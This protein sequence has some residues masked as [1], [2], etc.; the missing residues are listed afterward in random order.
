VTTRQLVD[1]LSEIEAVEALRV[2]AE[3]RAAA[4]EVAAP[5]E[6]PPI[7]GPRRP[8]ARP[9]RPTVDSTAF[10]TSPAARAA[11]RSSHVLTASGQR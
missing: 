9:S 3:R 7:L 4:V 10:E 6:R 5:L 11:R 2:I 1:E 8:S